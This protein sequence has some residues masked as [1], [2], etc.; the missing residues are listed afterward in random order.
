[1]A[2]ND[3]RELRKFEQVKVLEGIEKHLSHQPR[4]ESKSR[5]KALRQPYWS[6]YRLRIE[7]IR[8]YYDVE[9][10]LHQVQV[11]RVLVKESRLTEEEPP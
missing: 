10:E 7:E 11:L 3:I 6:Q 1:L 4:L 5:I 8:V 2:E 9:D